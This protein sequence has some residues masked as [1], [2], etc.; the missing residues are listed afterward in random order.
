M[1]TSLEYIDRVCRAGVD[2][3]VLFGSTGEFV[4]YD[5]DERMRAVSLAVKRSRVPALVN[6]SHSCLQGAVEL[7]QQAEMAGAKGVL[8]MPP[9]FFRYPDEEIHQFY[10]AFVERANLRVPI[11]LYNLPFF[12]NPL[13]LEVIARLFGTGLFAGIKDSGVDR[14]H[15]AGV[16]AG[17]EGKS[18][19]VLVGN[20]R[21]YGEGLRAGADGIVSGV[22]AA[23]P[24]L[25]VALR[26]A[27]PEDFPK[28]FERL[29]EF[30][31]WVDRFPASVV[32]KCAA[33]ARGWVPARFATPLGAASCARLEEF[34][35]WFSD[36][37][38]AVRP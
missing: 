6:V 5:L 29:K 3:I 25:I 9:Y 23:L 26:I 22:A 24:E 20:E 14:E 17:R 37:W 21:L 27:T 34:R 2:G 8:L 38:P 30:L 16:L 10:V 33:E 12:T 32:I 19:R 31:A 4:H 15:F 18:H 28:L 36:W 35:R 13:S 7:A 11:Y 1:S